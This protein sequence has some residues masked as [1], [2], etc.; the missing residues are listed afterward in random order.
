MRFRSLLVSGVLSA[1]AAATTPAAEHGSRARIRVITLEQAYDRTLESDQSIRRAYWEIR[2][3][4]LEPW[5]ALTRLGPSLTGGG[6]IATRRQTTRARGR[7]TVFD[8]SAEGTT[9][10]TSSREVTS[11]TRTRTDTGS[12][13]ITF[14]QTILDLTA[15]PAY[16]LGRLTAQ[17][18]KLTY[19]FT[20]RDVLFG[21][22]QAYYEV[23]KQQR[24][25][26]VSRE[27]LDLATQQLDLSQKRADVG[28]VTRSDVLRAQVTVESNRRAVIEAENALASRRNTLANILNLGHSAF[29][30]VEP[31]QYSPALA[32]FETLLARALDSREDL[33][34][35][36]IAIDQ[37]IQR[38]NVV[39]AGYAPRL[40]AQASADRTN[41]SGTSDSRNHSWDATLSV[42]IPFFTGGQREIDLAQARYQIQQT[43]LDYEIATKNVQ[44]EVKDAWLLVRTLAETLKALTVQVQ[45]AQQAYEDIRNQYQAGTA[46]SVDVLSALNEL[47]L[48]RRDLATQTYD[49]QVAL[50]NVEQLTG[51]YQETRVRRVKFR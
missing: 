38:R 35:Q 1:V 9:S 11:T 29:A 43:Q 48:A 51:V 31:A 12:I 30:I 18:A 3:A 7:E 49:Y 47:N 36:S 4:N 13:D 6:N 41:V 26:A 2:K 20:I 44:Q 14:Q 28:E 16:R 42:Q 5:S 25:A 17:A 10:G 19:Q 45:S 8:E 23:L 15:I 24:V 34:V 33:R 32:P 22:A 50:R 21:V 46:T 27:T 39:A 37:D 40:V